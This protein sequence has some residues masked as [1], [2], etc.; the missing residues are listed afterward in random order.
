MAKTIE[1][2]ILDQ[3]LEQARESLKRVAT[4]QEWQFLEGISTEDGE[5]I[6]RK[7]LSMASWGSKLRVI[8]EPTSPTQTRLILKKEEAFAITDFGRG[9]RDARQ[10]FAALGANPA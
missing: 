3:P 1:K 10:I 4:E 8:L 5:M 9:R 6:F 7:G 2:A